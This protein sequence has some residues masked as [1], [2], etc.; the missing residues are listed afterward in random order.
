MPPSFFGRGAEIEELLSRLQPILA[1]SPRFVALIGPSGSGKS[2]LVRAGLV[3]RLERM[4]ARWAVVP[5]LKPGNRPLST[6]ARRLA[7]ALGENDWRQIRDRIERDPAELVGLTDDLLHTTGGNAT[8][9]LLVIDQAEELVTAEAEERAAFLGALGAALEEA[10]PLWVVATLRSEYVTAVLQEPAIAGVIGPAV[11][12]G[13]LDRSRIP[14][15][16]EEPARRAGVEL[17]PGLV[18]RMVEE[19]RGGDALPLLAY[20]LRQLYERAGPQRRITT[21]DYEA[22]GGVLGALRRRADS[23][24]EE[25]ERSGKGELIIPTLL[26]FANVEQDNEPIG[27]RVLRTNLTADEGDVVQAFV[28]ARLLTTDGA[29]DDAVVGVAHDS[30]LRSWAPLRQAIDASREGLRLRSELER[31]ADE[32]D[33][34]GRPGSYLLREERLAGA[35]SFLESEIGRGEPRLVQ[36]FVERS[37]AQ[38]QAV[39]RR[40]ADLLASRVL[41]RLEEDPERGLLLALAAVEEYTPSPRAVHALNAAVVASRV[42]L[43]LRGHED[44][45]WSVAFSPDGSRVVTA[46][47]DKTA[48]LWD[49]ASGEELQVL[50]GHT[51]TVW[52][53]VFSPDGSR[54]VTASADG[55]AR[56]WDAASGGELH[57]LPWEG[58]ADATGADR[59]AAFSPDGSRVVTALA[60]ETPRLWDAASGDELQALHGHE[61][62]VW[63]A[64]FSP[65]GSRVVT[66]SADG[67][68]RLWDSVSGEELQVLRS[69]EG[70][71]GSAAFSPDGGQ[72]V[73]VPAA[74]M[75]RVWDVA[76]GEELQVLRGHEFGARTAVFSPDG[77]QVVTASTDR[78]ARLWDAASGKELQALRGHEHTVKSAVFSPD[79]SRVVTASVDGTARLWDAASGAELRVLSGDDIPG[80]VESAAFSPDGSRVATVSIFGTARLWDAASGEELQALHGAGSA[81][82]SPDGCQVV[83]VSTDR[84]AR[85]LDAA[86]GEELQVLRGHEHTVK[87]AVFSPDGSR[88]LTASYDGTARLWDAASGEE[89]QT[90][91][92]NADA[93]RSAAYS[94]DGSRVVTASDDGMVR[95]W[96]I[97][98]VELLVAKARSRVARELTGAERA[99]YGLT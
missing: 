42:R 19:T 9:A 18:G 96:E 61:D 90:L 13:L 81:A 37:R 78:T 92:G 38:S 74:G 87:S 1:S 85:L 12:L 20:T 65:D 26:R 14:E 55:T 97:L 72:V 28:E 53:A 64:A 60:D 25:L 16:I 63:G 51:D 17:E 2:S 56:V 54:V 44:D 32:W 22:I 4:G 62:R 99:E 47:P 43:H 80:S 39:L 71:V 58:A 34:V 91:Q 30:L 98:P 83:A 73:T 21:D 49:A 45:V 10:S 11:V 6:L 29:G 82:F 66:A 27:R 77:S 70:A 89:L 57:V 23:I 33:A 40:E 67:T 8:S 68:A 24:A 76:S 41:E 35:S 79:A 7:A 84:T 5:P 59:Y 46:S 69:R 3:P 50:R 75:P 31:L 36:E 95:V 93:V 86:S 88:V 48:R 52:S 94:P 15:V